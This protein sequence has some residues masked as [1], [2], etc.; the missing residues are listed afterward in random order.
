MSETEQL[1]RHRRANFIGAPEALN[2]NVVCATLVEAFGHNIYLVG[3][4]I[5]RRDYRDVDVR[6]ILDD[7]EYDNLFQNNTQNQQLSAFWCLVCAAI[8]EWIKSRT[9]LPIDFQIQKRSE[10]NEQ[11]PKQQ[12]S[13]LGLFAGFGGKVYEV[14]KKQDE[15]DHT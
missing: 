15:T 1:G 12:R 14:V 13:A 8:S 10:A 9:G 3:S 2:L 6:C 4:A 11:Y 5:E 7:E